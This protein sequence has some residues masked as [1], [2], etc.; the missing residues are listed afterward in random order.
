MAGLYIK[1]DVDFWDHPKIVTA[2]VM[3]G[4]LYQRMSMY[5]M[6]H[7]TDGFVP[8]AQVPR[9]A[10][11]SGAKLLGALLDAGLIE[12][13]DG[14]WLVPGYVER[15]LSAAELE[16]RRQTNAENGRKG[17]R[18]RTEQKPRSVSD[19][20]ADGLCDTKPNENQEVEV[21]VELRNP[22]PP[23]VT[24]VAEADAPVVAVAD[25]LVARLGYATPEP[26][27]SDIRAYV[28]RALTRGWAVEQ[29]SDLAIEAGAR[30]GVSDPLAWFRGALKRCANEDPPARAGPAPAER[31]GALHDERQ[32][33]ANPDCVGGMVGGFGPDG[34]PEPV[35]PCPDCHVL[36]ATA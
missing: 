31:R 8:A 10:L 2:G 35:R 27:G 17:G 1:L 36:G 32:P 12:R 7:T 19:G 18:P 33:C 4:V 13:A 14:G 28:A 23:T 30:D 11:P 29:L 22:P 3:A 9:F 15:Y 34:R 6:Q 26:A 20:L 5:C 21:D 25:S 16:R 24:P